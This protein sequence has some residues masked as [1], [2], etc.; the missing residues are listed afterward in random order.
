MA[1]RP[2]PRVLTSPGSSDPLSPPAR[3]KRGWGQPWKQTAWFTPPE[4]PAEGLDA[5]SAGR[6]L[7][8]IAAD[9]PSPS[10]VLKP[11]AARLPFVSC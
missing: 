5:L 9:R 7:L 11:G 8:S 4:L 2:F 10:L 1:P 3:D 6:P